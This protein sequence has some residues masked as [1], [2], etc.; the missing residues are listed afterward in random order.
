MLVKHG[1]VAEGR[2][3]VGTGGERCKKRENI[4]HRGFPSYP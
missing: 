1:S 3:E 2:V 4:R